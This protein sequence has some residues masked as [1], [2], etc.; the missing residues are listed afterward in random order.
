MDRIESPVRPVPVAEKST[1]IR[2]FDPTSNAFVC[3]KMSRIVATQAAASG[4]TI[5]TNYFSREGC[6]SGPS[7]PYVHVAGKEHTWQLIE[8]LLSPEG[9]YMPGF[10]V[11]CYDVSMVKYLEIPSGVVMPTSGSASY[12][13]QFNNSGEN[14]KARYQLCGQFTGTG[15]CAA[16]ERC[17]GIHCIATNFSS[18]QCHDTHVGDEP[19]LLR[20]Y[21]RLPP[22]VTVRAYQ[23]NSSEDYE[24][25][26]G[27]RVLLTQGA[28]L[29][30]DLFRS[31]GNQFPRKKMQHCAHFR[32]KRLCR[33][34]EACKFIHVVPTNPATSSVASAPALGTLPNGTDD[35]VRGFVQASTTSPLRSPRSDS[36]ESP[37]SDKNVV[38]KTATRR[39]GYRS[40]TLADVPSGPTATTAKPTLG[41]VAAMFASRIPPQH[42]Q[43]PTQEAFAYPQNPS[44]QVRVQFAPQP[45]AYYAPAGAQ[46]QLPPQQQQQ[47]QGIGYYPTVPNYF[48]GGSPPLNPPQS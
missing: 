11:R 10:V 28:Q 22:D 15:V 2:L 21:R 8:P 27:D 23:Q 30:A 35:E 42:A 12:I 44:T 37:L 33:M 13:D 18:F 24:D 26:S 31:E 29:Y 34:G 19:S 3:A 25:F 47:Q 14:F 40:P 17:N 39:S 5:C 6:R 36:T 38:V 32:L 45:G 41:N 4:G 46:F 7:C 48:F 43:A 1:G 20:Y 9:K 16:A